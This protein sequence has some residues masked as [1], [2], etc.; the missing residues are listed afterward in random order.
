MLGSWISI[1]NPFRDW[2]PV[3]RLASPGDCQF[4]PT[5]KKQKMNSY[6]VSVYGPAQGEAAFTVRAARLARAALASAQGGA[7]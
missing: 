7:K 1:S 5:I 4:R 3:A 2:N 6:K